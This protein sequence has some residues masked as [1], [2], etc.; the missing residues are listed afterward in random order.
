MTDP[1]HYGISRGVIVTTLWVGS[2]I[3]FFAYMF[4]RPTPS[5][6]HE[7]RRLFG[8]LV[9]LNLTMLV[10]WLLL[11]T[12]STLAR[13]SWLAAEGI[14]TA[15][16]FLT[17]SIFIRRYLL[18]SRSP[19]SSRQVTN[20]LRFCVYVVGTFLVLNSI[21]IYGQYFGENPQFYLVVDAINVVVFVGISLY[22]FA[23]HVGELLQFMGIVIVILEVFIALILILIGF[24][25]EGQLTQTYHATQPAMTLAQYVDQNL[26][27]LAWIIIGSN[28]VVLLI[29]P[30]LLRR[31]MF[32]P[33][34]ALSGGARR[35]ASGDL[36]I[37]IP[38]Y[39]NDEIGFLTNA[40]N[41]MVAS[42]RTSREALQ[43]VNETLEQRVA[44]RTHE[45]SLAR[46]AAEVA[47]TAK[48]TFLANMSHE[49]RT[50]L[51][52]ILGYAQML[53]RRRVEPKAA[54]VIEQSGQH[55]L[56]LIDDVLDMAKVET[57]KLTLAATKFNLPIFLNQLAK[58]AQPLAESKGL[59]FIEDFDPRLPQN[60]ELD[61]KRLRQVLLNL[62]SNATK[63]SLE[64]SITLRIG[65]LS[66]SAD[67]ALVRFEVIDTGIGIPV[68]ELQNI[69]NPFYQVNRI[70]Q[71]EAHGTGL[72]LAIS[73][74]L[75]VLLGGTLQVESIVGAG[76]RFW[77]DIPLSF[78]PSRV[79]QSP[80][81]TIVTGVRNNPT[82]LLVDDIAINRMMLFDLLTPLGCRVLE[83]E[84][85]AV[86]LELLKSVTPDVLIT[87]LIMPQVDG[88]MLIRRVKE[89]AE[90]ANLPI[91]AISASTFDH[92]IKSSLAIGCDAFLA[93]PVDT[94]EL[95]ETLAEVGGIE[96][97][98]TSEV[99]P[100]ED[101]SPLMILPTL[102]TLES[103]LM[104]AYRGDIEEIEQWTN[105][106]SA[107]LH[108][109]VKR[110]QQFT[111]AYQI[112]ALCNWLDKQIADFKS[113][114][115][116]IPS[117]PRNL[118]VNTSEIPRVRAE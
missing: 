63:F 112:D 96:W 21:V 77:F 7:S 107:E 37:H 78:A 8:L 60:V 51:N 66:S 101:A 68:S 95:L 114:T 84:N 113:T 61:S 2:A 11:P 73:Q 110:L 104:H 38:T 87:D 27:P 85:G 17:V 19:D 20:G 55:L 48:T 4:P 67:I 30:I 52:A 58:M 23:R 26:R 100:I 24:V 14:F 28:L 47:N 81:G 41:E 16:L 1:W 109:F 70:Q 64:G 108:P 22:T 98:H 105:H 76:S 82:I 111:N 117:A 92:H 43:Q 12:S 103:L 50:P 36:D 83:A 18:E 29:L 40:F 15:L 33:L 45:L 86:A 46:D 106:A 59:H 90:F 94:G 34:A 31:I 88:Y 89:S 74:D 91:I 56:M 62:L 72:G 39:H 3:V 25:F 9:V 102:E 49:L 6:A 93:K 118:A 115:S 97:V 71:T 116:V 13:P 54:S 99:Q 79:A 57:G 42:I 35:V 10:Y 44:E 75:V 69:F 65:L 5:L 80:E 32:R 53:I